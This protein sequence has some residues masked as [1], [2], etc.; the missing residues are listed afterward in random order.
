MRKGGQIEVTGLLFVFSTGDIG[1]KVDFTYAKP[2]AT[3]STLDFPGGNFSWSTEDQ[4]I[5][6]AYC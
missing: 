3:F 6:G 1:T 5:A 4:G 2:A